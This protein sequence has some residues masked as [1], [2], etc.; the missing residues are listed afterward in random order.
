MTKAT[1]LPDFPKNNYYILLA[2]YWDLSQSAGIILIKPK[3]DSRYCILRHLLEELVETTILLAFHIASF[4]S[5]QICSP[6]LVKWLIKDSEWPR[7][8]K[9]LIHQE[10]DD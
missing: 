7:M 10:L 9:M 6:N 2:L 3:E 8:K 1:I 4:R 5:G